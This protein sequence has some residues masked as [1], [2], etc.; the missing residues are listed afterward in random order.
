MSLV[1]EVEGDDAVNAAVRAAAARLG[2]SRSPRAHVLGSAWWRAG[3]REALD[4]GAVGLVPAGRYEATP[5]P[6]RTRGATRA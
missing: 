5:P 2:L 3:L 4:R 6:R 1:I